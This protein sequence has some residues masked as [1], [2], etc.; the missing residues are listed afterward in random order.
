MFRGLRRGGQA[1][2]RAECEAILERGSAGVLALAG[3]GGYP[4]AVPLSYLYSDGEII[5]HCAKEG[6]KID[7]IRRCAKASF[8]V[9]DKDEVVPQE[10]ATRFRSVIA[11][12]TMSIIEDEAKKRE[13]ITRLAIKYAPC[14]SAENRERKIDK[15]WGRLCML[16]MR[17]EHLS[18]KEALALAKERAAAAAKEKEL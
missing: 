18:G 9:V 8:C 13:A 3:D 2:E 4:Y 6:H 14:D 16:L 17:V 12:G 5:F 7:A 1:L 10:Y 15:D 11:F